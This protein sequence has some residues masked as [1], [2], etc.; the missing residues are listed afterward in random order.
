MV[1]LYSCAMIKKLIEGIEERKA[2]GLIKDICVLASLFCMIMLHLHAVNGSFVPA[3]Y[4]AFYLFSLML[5]FTS[6]SGI[7]MTTK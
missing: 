1:K 6:I 4:R 3:K 5:F 7:L 2:V